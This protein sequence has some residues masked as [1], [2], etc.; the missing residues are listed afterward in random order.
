VLTSLAFIN[1]SQGMAERTAILSMFETGYEA[2]SGHEKDDAC[3]LD[4]ALRREAALEEEALRAML[5]GS[6]PDP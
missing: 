5:A 3:W 1:H 6:D 2:Q 4:A